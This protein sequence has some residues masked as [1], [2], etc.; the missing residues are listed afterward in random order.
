M[1]GNQKI[2]CSVKSCEHYEDG[3]CCCLD[4]IKVTPVKGSA[5]GK[6]DESMCSNYKHCN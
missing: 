1:E 5:T 3:D 6:S 2:C 4:K